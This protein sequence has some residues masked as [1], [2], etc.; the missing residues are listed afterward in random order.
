VLDPAKKASRYSGR[1]TRVVGAALILVSL[2][3]LAAPLTA[4]K[5][6]LQ[7]LSLFP[8]TV[9]LIDL[10]RAIRDPSLR[11][12]PAAYVTGILAIGAALLLYLSPSLVI[13]GVITLLL[14]FIILDGVLKLGQA[15]LWP[16]TNRSRVVMAANGISNLVLALVGWLL[17]K[18][19]GVEAAIAVAVAG[20]TAT[21]GWRMLVSP[22]TREGDVE[23]W[24]SD[25]HPDPKIG[26]GGNAL[27]GAINKERSASAPAIW[28]NE[29]YWLL[30]VAVVLLAT[31][32]AR[33][34][35]VETWLG[36]ISPFVATAGDVLMAIAL[37]TLL[38][39]PARL[40]WRRITR[41]IERKA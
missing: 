15:L 26:L 35:S 25:A 5:W 32:V 31:H 23:T 1:L 40:L 34:Q 7:F 9:G 11:T 39:L 37:G 10:Y 2:L 18:N 30:V 29:L 33:M 27:F 13:S 16:A 12:R 19:V 17:W 41:P 4:G 8:L 21:A 24:P 3:A 22:A 14:G 38:V 20:Y 6:S 36:L 28:Q